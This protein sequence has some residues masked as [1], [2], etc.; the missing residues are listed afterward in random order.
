MKNKY[1]NFPPFLF[2]FLLL[3]SGV[4]LKMPFFFFACGMDLMI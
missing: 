1:C 4:D 3:T 2:L